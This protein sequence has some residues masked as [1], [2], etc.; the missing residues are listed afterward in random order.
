MRE[1]DFFESAAQIFELLES[2][3]QV[4]LYSSI[5]FGE[6]L[7]DAPDTSKSGDTLERFVE[8]FTSGLNEVSADRKVCLLAGSLRKERAM[9]LPDA[10]H[11]ASAIQGGAKVFVSADKKLLKAAGNYMKIQAIEPKV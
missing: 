11:L 1:Q 9:K 10:I 3:E 4:G 5:M 2:G 8:H 6:V 7:V